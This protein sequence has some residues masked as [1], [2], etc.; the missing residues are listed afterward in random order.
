MDNI[1]R[2][3][4]VKTVDGNVTSGGLIIVSQ[5]AANNTDALASGFTMGSA[6]R[7]PYLEI[8]DIYHLL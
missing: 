1:L 8:G 7:L 3:Y 6:Y 5:V 4:F 2:Q